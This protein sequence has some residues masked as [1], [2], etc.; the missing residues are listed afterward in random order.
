MIS[1]KNGCSYC[2]LLSFSFHVDQSG[3]L[4]KDDDYDDIL[5]MR[6]ET[7]NLKKIPKMVSCN[8]AVE[9]S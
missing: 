4:E 7:D 8:A 1:G 5:D 2:R 3:S 6:Q 9:V